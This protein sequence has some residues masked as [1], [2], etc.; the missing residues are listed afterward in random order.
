MI[1]EL[2]EKYEQ[3]FSNKPD[4]VVRAPGRINLIGEHTDYNDG[5]VLPA[6]INKAIYIAVGKRKD[7]EVRLYSMDFKTSYSTDL[8]SLVPIK[9]WAT[10]ITGV[11]AQ[12]LKA[13][14]NING[15][16]LVMFGD[17]PLGAGLSSSAAVECSVAFAINELYNLGFTKM[18][19]VQFSQRAE[20]EFAGV[21]CG[22]MDQFASIFGKKNHVVKLDCRSLDYEYFSLNMTDV[23]IVLMDTGVKHSLASSEYNTRRLQC[24]EGIAAIQKKYPAVQKLRD[25]TLEMLNEMVDAESA[26]YKRCLYV[27]TE[28]ER[29]QKACIDL[30][31]N[32]IEAFGKKMYATHDG[33]SELYEVSCPELDFLVNEVRDDSAILGARMM[34]GGFGGCTINL[35]KSNDVDAVLNRVGL[36]YQ[37]AFNKS[38]LSYTVNI[39]E[40]ASFA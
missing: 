1:N 32:R 39:E 31:Q 15:F 29:V 14:G 35:I 19:L 18:E 10:Y 20:H 4:V 11:V 27:I 3:L 36:A 34:G 23:S 22:L 16:N 2:K 38:L 7:Q 5:F 17:V 28:I 12:M 13:G 26:V 24:E 6:A 37:K 8:H 25:A 30:Q 9:S 33:L 21:K 40:G